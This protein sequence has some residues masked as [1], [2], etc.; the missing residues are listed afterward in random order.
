MKQPVR[1]FTILLL[2]GGINVGPRSNAAAEPLAPLCTEIEA[3]LS[4]NAAGFPPFPTNRV[5]PGSG[6]TPDDV[7]KRGKGIPLV[8]G[9]Y[10]PWIQRTFVT[11]KPEHVDAARTA[12]GSDPT[13]AV[14]VSPLVEIPPVAR[15]PEGGDGWRLIAAGPFE[16]PTIAVSAT[17]AGHRQLWAALGVPAKQRRAVRANEVL[18]SYAIHRSG[19]CVA[20]RISG[21]SLSSRLNTFQVERAPGPPAGDCPLKRQPWSAVVALDRSRFPNRA[22]VFRSCQRNIDCSWTYLVVDFSKKFSFGTAGKISRRPLNTGTCANES[23]TAML[24]PSM[25]WCEVIERFDPNRFVASTRYEG[26][27]VVFYLLSPQDAP[28]ELP[29]QLIAAGPNTVAMLHGNKLKVRRGNR[30]TEIL[31]F[32]DGLPRATSSGPEGAI[33]PSGTRVAVFLQASG[34]NRDSDSVAVGLVDVEQKTMRVVPT[35]EW[36]NPM[37]T[38]D[39]VL[40]VGSLTI[41]ALNT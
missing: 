5:P 8:G 11:V 40:Q 10:Y 29:G 6:L 16:A 34:A 36:Q 13:N 19:N 35:S 31:T 20:D 30:T 27:Q 28:V 26:G 32:T 22:V 12:F 41:D 39:S 18:V 15:Q 17:A 2:L 1:V 33:N 25:W 38:S 7:L 3:S 37:W 24:P 4:P 9:G 21:F 14:C 23:P